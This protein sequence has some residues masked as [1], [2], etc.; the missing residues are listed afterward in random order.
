MRYLETTEAAWLYIHIFTSAYNPITITHTDMD[1]TPAMCC[2]V[3]LLINSVV[4]VE[5]MPWMLGCWVA[6]FSLCMFLLCLHKDENACVSMV[7]WWTATVIG[8]DCWMN[9]SAYHL[10][11]TEVSVSGF[12]GIS[13]VSTDLSLNFLCYQLHQGPITCP[14]LCPFSRHSL[15]LSLAVAIVMNWFWGWNDM[16]VLEITEMTSQR[17]KELP[18]NGNS[19]L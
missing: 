2:F 1:E 12:E 13:S 7:S 14:F 6:W 19:N 17:Q 9:C 3:V 15:R 16:R 8:C 4:E 5:I 11:L 10:K 18:S